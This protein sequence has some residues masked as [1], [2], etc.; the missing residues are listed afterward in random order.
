MRRFAAPLTA[1]ALLGLMF[2]TAF[3]NHTP[4]H[5]LLALAFMLGLLAYAFVNRK[6]LMASLKN[7]KSLPPQAQ[8]R[9]HIILMMMLL[10][11]G[12]VVTGVLAITSEWDNAVPMHSLLVTLALGIS[13]I[14]LLQ[15][16]GGIIGTFKGE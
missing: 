2:A 11:T 14:H 9:L 5:G 6:W 13:M 1:V 15:N 16:L 12:S 8:L 7:R 10:W 4:M 3:S